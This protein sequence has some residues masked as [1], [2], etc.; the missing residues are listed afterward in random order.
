MPARIVAEVM[1]L[2]G[3]ETTFLGAATPVAHLVEFVREQQ[4]RAVAMSCSVP[5]ALPRVREMV[6]GVRAELVPTLLGGRGVRDRRT[7]DLLGADAYGATAAA[8][9]YALEHLPA[10]T[11]PAPPMPVPDDAAAV[12]EAHG[13]DVADA[14]LAQV[15]ACVASFAN[16]AAVQREHTRA[17]LEQVVG[18]TVAALFVDDDRILVEFAEWMDGVLTS[19]GLPGGVTDLAL[20]ATAGAMAELGLPRALR[21]VD[22]ARD[23]LRAVSARR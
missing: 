21:F 6:E 17:D 11:T 23:R 15:G 12:L 3:W 5:T 20:A 22:A 13:R 4:P 7:A 18:F 1:R 16:M 8:A 19:R 14:A 9:V 2:A 10:A